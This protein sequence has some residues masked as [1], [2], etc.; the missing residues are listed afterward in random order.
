M[1]PAPRQEIVPGERIYLSHVRRSDLPA[2]AIGVG[3]THVFFGPRYLITV[4]HGV[5]SDHAKKI[6]RLVKDTKLKVQ[7]SI[8]EAQVRVTGKNRD[9]LQETITLQTDTIG[10]LQTTLRA[11]QRSLT[12]AWI[13]LAVPACFAIVV[14]AYFV[15]RT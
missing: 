2:F 3:E 10:R 9:D 13:L 14:M 5:S 8:Q 11:T 1:T 15:F 7:A 12:L 6:V 4:R